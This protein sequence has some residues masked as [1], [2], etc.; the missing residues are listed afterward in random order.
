[1]QVKIRY[2]ETGFRKPDY[3]F[4]AT[5]AD[6]QDF[7]GD[8]YTPDQLKRALAI[9]DAKRWGVNLD[10][11]GGKNERNPSQ[12]IDEYLRYS[13]LK[14][15]ILTDGQY[16]RIYERNSSKHNIYY[17]VDLFSLL[18]NGGDDATSDFY[19]FYL[20]FRRE[21]FVPG[22]WLERILDGSTTYAENLSDQLE[23]EVYNALE[24]IAQG[25]L[26]YRR[27]RL[28][29]A[30]ATLQIIYEHSLVLLYRLLFV[31]YAESRDILPMT[32]N[33]AYADR[34][35]LSAIKKEVAQMVDFHPTALDRLVDDGTIYS[36]LS[37]LFFNI[38]QGSP[39]YAISPYNGRLFSDDEHTFLADKFVGGAYLGKAI[40]R[41]ARVPDTTDKKGKKRVFVDY[42]DLDIRHL[43][44]I[45]EKLLEYQLDIATEP[46]T[47]KKGK[48]IPAKDGDTVIKQP[49]QVF[50]R[51]GNN[52]R[53]ITGSYY[54]PD[55]IVS[56]IVQH[57]LNHC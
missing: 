24:L 17:E 50:L 28:E 7:T 49:G 11:S 34:Q 52:E 55:Y 15:G 40:D 30:P 14:W 5:E 47:L 4:T 1:M 51:T 26:N 35:S 19:Y 56:F 22:G 3:L 32:D 6:V 18:K 9:G 27:N 16:W 13:E 2:R 45:Y 37:T 38:D 20:F 43:G 10:R 44:A 54:T 46:L 8:I 36:R 23:D 29:A 25:F 31:F 57:T 12:Q 39:E 42:R 33:K 53:K 41:L 21:A 48:Y